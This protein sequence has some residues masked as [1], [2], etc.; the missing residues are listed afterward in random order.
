MEVS[1]QQSV[2]SDLA[3]FIASQPT[4]EDVIAYHVPAALEMRVHELLDK[5]REE[6][7]TSEEREEMHK[8]LAISHLMTLAKA[9]A[10]L[11]L[12]GKA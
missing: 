4:L 2:F 12:A 10:R 5:N 9:R 11:R 3:D 6:G 7:L 8:F 1:A